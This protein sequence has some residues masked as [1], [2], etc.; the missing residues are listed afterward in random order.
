MNSSGI[1]IQRFEKNLKIVSNILMHI[2]MIM[3]FAMMCLGTFDVM[4]RYFFNTPIKGTLEIFEMLLPAI[5]LL[6]LAITQL[7]GGHV[8]IGL[9]YSRVSRKMQ[10]EMDFII[11][12]ILMILFL[13]ITWREI[14]TIKVYYN[15]GRLIS[16]IGIPMYVPL[17]IAPIGTLAICPV[18]FFQL[19]NSYRKIGRGG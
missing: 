4:G 9:L 18:L 14:E 11:C 12:L 10:A 2:A 19:I 3:L 16:N 6:S 5:V 15:Q 17:T 1:Q 7:E 13:V 8:T